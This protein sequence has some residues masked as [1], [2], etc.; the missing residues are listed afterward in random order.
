MP[1][2]GLNAGP[3]AC[4]L[5][6]TTVVV[7]VEDTGVMGRMARAV[8]SVATMAWEAAMTTLALALTTVVA[9]AATGER[10][11]CFLTLRQSTQAVCC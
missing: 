11:Y 8:R 4:R 7:A 3:F 10:H 9:V 1:E 6:T 5:T 2:R